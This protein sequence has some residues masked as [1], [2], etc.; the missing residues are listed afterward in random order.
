MGTVTGLSTA[1]GDV[2][3][4]QAAAAKQT[5]VADPAISAW[6]SANAGTG[7]THVLVRRVL[8]L[9]LSGAEP[10]GI[11]CLTF[12]KA[13]A[14]QMTGRLMRELGGWAAADELALRTEVTALL[15]RSP[16]LDELTLARCLFTRVLDAPSGLKIMTIHAFCERILRRFPLEA[17]VPPSFAVLTDE[18]QNALLRQAIDAALMTA[19]SDPDSDLGR[20]LNHTVAHAAEDR[21]DALLETVVRKR[22][23]LR[24]LFLYSGEHEPFARIDHLLR[25]TLG[26]GARDDADAIL[27]EQA[28]LLPDPLIAPAVC[29]ADGR[30]QGR[31]GPR[32]KTRGRAGHVWYAPGRGAGGGFPDEGR[33]ATRRQPV[34]Q[35]AD[36]QSLP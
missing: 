31:P 10:Q 16:S 28:A 12:T 34:H 35:Q 7:K 32:G 26:I 5:L 9:L 27:A 19:A 4:R 30:R 36:A 29:G 21:F 25:K 13:A 22:E 3:V 11:L 24:A 17:G 6:V 20:A 14:A 18:E 1:S 2:A 8:R 23:E 15:G 33:R